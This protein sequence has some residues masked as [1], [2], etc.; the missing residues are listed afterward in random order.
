MKGKIENINE[1]KNLKTGTKDGNQWTLYGTNITINGQKIGLTSFVKQDLEETIANLKVGDKVEVETETDGK[2]LNLKKGSKIK[3]INEESN[4]EKKCLTD[5]EI[6]KIW[7]DS[8]DEVINHLKTKGFDFSIMTG[9]VWTAVG[10]SVNTLF[11]KKMEERR[12][13]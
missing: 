1:I 12:R 11:M 4:N 5:Q 2:Y 13:K 8:A 9:E 6:T 10:P 3:L 7:I